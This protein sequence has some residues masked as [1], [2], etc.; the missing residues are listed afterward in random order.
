VSE[1]RAPALE[2]L[3]ARY[4]RE[5]KSVG[6]EDGYQEESFRQ[7]GREQLRQ[8]HARISAAPPAL[9]EQELNFRLPLANDVVLAGRIDQISQ[10]PGGGSEIV[11][12][13]TGT[14]RDEKYAKKSLQLSYYA[15]AARDALELDRPRMA[16]HYLKNDT[17]VFSA[18]DDKDIAEAEATL[19]EVA[20]E[21]RAGQFP[22][23]PG[24]ACRFCDYRL[25]C[26][27]HERGPSS[28]AAPPED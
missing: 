25:I 20:S 15:L 1:G 27:A 7:D 4:D 16:F 22:A 8:F 24:F 9:V 13:K 28:P 21:I 19:Q 6:F 2:E 10:L 3:L 23:T 12:Y 11:D 17:V 14:P 26:P 5:W 18:R